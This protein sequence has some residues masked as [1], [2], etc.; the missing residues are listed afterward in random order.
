[1]NASDRAALV[2]WVKADLCPTGKSVAVMVEQIFLWCRDRKIN[3]P[4]SSEIE[5]IVR[6]ERHRFLEGW[7]DRVT[8][9][10]PD[11]TLKLME[12]SL[13]D[14]DGSSGFH[15]IKA[16][17]GRASLENFLNVTERLAFIQSLHQD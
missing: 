9:R 14:P 2:S 8:N 10:L 17:A 5:R 16:D 11:E 3:R 1:L 13:S 15:T 6:S 7:L 4:A 12:A